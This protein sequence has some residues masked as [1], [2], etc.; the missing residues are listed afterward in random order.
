MSALITDS[1]INIELT[2][3]TDTNPQTNYVHIL[4]ST[5]NLTVNTSDWPT[6]EHIRVAEVVLQSAGATV[7]GG[8][9]R[10]QNW[11]DH[12]QNTTGGEGHLSD[13]GAAIRMKIPA[14]WMSGIE[15]SSSIDTGSTPDDVWVSTTSGVIMQMHHQVFTAFDTETVSDICVMN[16]PGAPYTKVTNLNVLLEDATGTTLNNSSFSF[17]HQ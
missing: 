14:T 11:N 10:N 2:P 8:A 1:G 6:A 7:S 3:G 17:V 5:K 13:I 4:E 12:I 9:L 16:Y 15:G